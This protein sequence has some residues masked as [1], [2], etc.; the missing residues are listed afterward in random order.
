MINYDNTISVNEIDNFI[1]N[2][3]SDKLRFV[4]ASEL[5]K[6]TLPTRVTGDGKF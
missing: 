2:L 1:S 3:K 6:S 4:S 5:Q